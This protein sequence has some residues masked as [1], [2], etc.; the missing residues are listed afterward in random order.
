MNQSPSIKELATALS[1]FQAQFKGA[2]K[3]KTN[4]FLRTKYADL[5]SVWHSIREP[6]TE[7]GLSVVQSLDHVNGTSYINTMI[8]HCSGEWISGACPL[9][10][11]KQNNAHSF[12]SAITYARRYSLSAAL[13]VSDTEDDGNTASGK[14]EEEKDPLK[15]TLGHPD[16]SSGNLSGTISGHSFQI[17]TTNELHGGTGG[18]SATSITP[19]QSCDHKWMK[20]KFS[21]NKLWCPKCNEKKNG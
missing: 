10:I 16:T 3:N 5:E 2:V 17:K 9:V 6:L 1:K 21:P 8:I 18:S 15:V 13:G 20:D 4:T 12:G 19:T 11:D 14:H 7:N